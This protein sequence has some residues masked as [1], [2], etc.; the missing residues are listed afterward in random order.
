MRAGEAGRSSDIELL[1]E[2]ATLQSR[3]VSVAL[4]ETIILE[5]AFRP[6]GDV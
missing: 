2:F 1:H 3:K 4:Q 6:Q 5:V